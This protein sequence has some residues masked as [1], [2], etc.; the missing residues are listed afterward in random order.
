MVEE[1]MKER[2]KITIRRTMVQ[3]IQFGTIQTWLGKG[4]IFFFPD[5]AYV[6][7]VDFLGILI[8]EFRENCN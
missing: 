3:M 7:Q 5:Y 6:V 4:W 1:T 8:S 2:T